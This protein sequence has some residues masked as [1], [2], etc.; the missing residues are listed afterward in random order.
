MRNPAM[1]RQV[2]EALA[3]QGNVNRHVIGVYRWTGD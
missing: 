1:T 2:L 3:K